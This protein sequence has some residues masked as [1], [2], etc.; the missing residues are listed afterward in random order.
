MNMKLN[1]YALL[2]AMVGL[3]CPL[4]AVA[5]PQVTL[6]VGEFVE[7]QLYGQVVSLAEGAFDRVGYSLVVEKLPNK[8]ALLR[9]RQGLNDGQ[10]IRV[11]SLNRNG[12]YP[13]LYLVKP[14][15][16]STRFYVF[17]ANPSRRVKSW[18][19]F[20]VTDTISYPA[21]IKVIKQKLEA[22]HRQGTLK[23]VYGKRNEPKYKRLLSQGL[24][25]FVIIPTYS[26]CQDNFKASGLDKYMLPDIFEET[27]IYVAEHQT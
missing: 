18:Q 2:L 26:M 16:A 21:G 15:L 9:S 12:E 11:F 19:A 20:K 23:E 25:D 1:I 22:N 17:A 24:V 3:L 27:L 10:L 8:R 7:A 6:A 13:N 5:K 4:Q 14:A